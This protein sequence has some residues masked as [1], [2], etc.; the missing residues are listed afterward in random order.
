MKFIS[1]SYDSNTGIS[2]VTM[3][4]LG[5]KFIGKAY[6]HP[7][8]KENASNYAGCEYAEIRAKIKALKYERMI[9]KNKSDMALDFIHACENY[10]NFNVEDA[11]AKVLYRQLN[12][13]IKR[14]NEI[15]DEIN[16]LYKE[17]DMKIHHRNIILNAIDRKKNLSKEDN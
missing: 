15:T 14:V 13:R 7:N 6:L 5:V 2:T 4:H 8:D 17:L 11:S 3:Q 12:R 16:K 10:T 9:E 1:S